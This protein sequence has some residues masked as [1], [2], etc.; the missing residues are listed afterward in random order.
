VIALVEMMVNFDHAIDFGEGDRRRRLLSLSCA[1]HP[2]ISVPA[3]RG[4]VRSV[5]LCLGLPARARE[6]LAAK[7][8]GIPPARLAVP[9]VVCAAAVLRAGAWC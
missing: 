1:S 3:P 9:V 6:I 5:V 8:S 7:T 2:I 4:L